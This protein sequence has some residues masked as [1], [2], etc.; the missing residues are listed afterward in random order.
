MRLRLHFPPPGFFL[1]DP[2][3]TVALDGRTVYD[4]SFK[5]GFDVEAE[6]QPG[7]LTLETAVAM[8]PGMARKQRIPID[9][10]PEAG[11]RDTPAVAVRLEY[12]R[13]FGNFKKRVS[14]AVRH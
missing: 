2:R 14:I 7:A 5:S 1:N 8:G 12:S 9:L 3:L 10:T 4:G 11:Y 6:V 13:F